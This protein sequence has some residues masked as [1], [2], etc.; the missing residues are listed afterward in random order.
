MQTL[1]SLMAFYTD[2]EVMSREEEEKRGEEW[3]NHLRTEGVE[4][5]PLPEESLL[6]PSHMPE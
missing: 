6:F 2:T 5:K 1:P 3:G 4:L